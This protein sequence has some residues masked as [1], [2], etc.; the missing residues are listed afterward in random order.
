MR[1]IIHG[2]AALL[3][4]AGPA[5]ADDGHLTRAGAIAILHPW[6]RA[7]TAAEGAVFMELI[8]EGGVADHLIGA[9]SPLAE[10]VELH[11]VMLKE[12]TEAAMPI[13]QL[14]LEPG[15][16]LELAPGLLSLQLIGLRAPLEQGGH[17]AV[18]LVFAQAGT[19]MVEVEIEA[20]DAQ[21]HSHAGHGH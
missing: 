6:A 11:G 10:R 15:T 16:T 12:G 18:E 1:N 8:N 7:T 17:F 4:I 9:R 21:A 5:M 14:T 2:F 20:A 13:E 3:L 19:V